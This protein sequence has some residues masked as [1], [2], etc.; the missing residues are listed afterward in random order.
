VPAV[1]VVASTLA[2]CN[3]ILGLSQL[4]IGEQDAGTVP[5]R[6]DGPTVSD[7]LPDNYVG[8][9]TTNAE[10]TDR[11]TAEGGTLPDGS[12]RIV[13]AVCVR[14]EA[15]CV[16]LLTDDC[17]E[18]T[19]DYRDDNAILLGT[20]FSTVG[21]QSAMNLQRQHSAT[22]AAE[23]INNV[24]GIPAPPGGKLQ[25]LVMLSCN[26]ANHALA[27]GVTVLT[28]AGEHLIKDLHVP[29]IV[30]PNTSQD[31][32]ALSNDLSVAAGTVLLT[33]TA[34]AASIAELMDNELTWLMVPS[35]QQRGPLMINQINQLE[36]ELKT[37]RGKSVIKLGIVYRKD[38]VGLGTLSSLDSLIINGKPL[39]DPINA[40]SAGGNVTIDGYDFSAANQDTIVNN[41]VKFAPDI[42]VL[43][44]LAEVITTVMDPIEQRWSG[45]AGS[46]RAY[47]VLTD[48]VKGPDLVMNS[49]PKM[50]SL[51]T[52]VRGTGITPGTLSGP[53]LSAF[54]LA[55][56][57]KYGMTPTASG[58]GP[59]YDSTYAIA[60]ALAAT[61]DLPVSGPTISKGLR[62]LAGG[63]NIEVG[64]KSI[65]TAFGRLVAGDNINA[66]GTF[67]PMEWDEKGAVVNGT[68]E[69]WCVGIPATAPAY[70]S[71]GLTYDIAAK[72]T[73]GV[74]FQCPP[75]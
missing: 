45:D 59:S 11:A 64:S 19:G 5:P 48:Q 69:I 65:G 13:P 32:I 1:F 24:G 62:K 52:R 27:P 34:V 56:R 25:K 33:P 29:A 30:G 44:G 31:T 40:G 21:A 75:P 4:S 3:S 73:M 39:N 7:V 47:Y 22:L 49:I 66:I 10:C 50:P 72:T 58:S 15:R 20:L 53:V 68:I 2:G 42:I 14:P 55:Y 74:Y 26:E 28:R 41:Y 43:A 37:V 6:P 12:T 18:I 67:V 60:Y 8:E 70:G 23:E 9:C 63:M 51:R 38:A 17:N 71:S 35:D 61:R 54:E 36:S 46:E 16:E 57:A